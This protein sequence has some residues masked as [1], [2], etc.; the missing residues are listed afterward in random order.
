MQETAPKRTTEA[1]MR[2]ILGTDTRLL[3]KILEPNST[4]RLPLDQGWTKAQILELVR[5]IYTGL[6]PDNYKI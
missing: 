3:A 6:M 4:I 2:D 5:D 1:K